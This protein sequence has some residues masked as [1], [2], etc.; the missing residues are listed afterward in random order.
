MHNV[1]LDFLLAS[2]SP[3]AR[4]S[5]YSFLSAAHCSRDS[6]WVYPSDFFD[7]SLPNE[8]AL[9][10]VL[11]LLS[12]LDKKHLYRYKVITYMALWIGNTKA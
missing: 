11:E 3:I 9:E 12:L 10:P 4:V 1:E 6:I 5:S 2:L 7:R 8:G